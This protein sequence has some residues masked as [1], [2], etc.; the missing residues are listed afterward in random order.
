MYNN[1][2]AEAA[3]YAIIHAPFDMNLLI[4]SIERLP[5][6]GMEIMALPQYPVL[7]VTRTG[8]IPYATKS[9]IMRRGSANLILLGGEE[10][11]SEWVAYVLSTL[12]KGRV[13]RCSELI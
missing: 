5:E 1:I 10:S 7:Y 2:F 8:Y 6:I 13:Y 4:I 9:E 12:T 3:E 11:I